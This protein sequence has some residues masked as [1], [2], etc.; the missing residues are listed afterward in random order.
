MFRLCLSSV[1]VSILTFLNEHHSI[2]FYPDRL[3]N[4]MKQHVLLIRPDFFRLNFKKD[5]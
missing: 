2:L 5:I 4:I 1:L 3:Q